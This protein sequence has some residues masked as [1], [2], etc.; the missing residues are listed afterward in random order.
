MLA[1]R[2]EERFQSASELISALGGQGTST[3]LVSGVV[4]SLDSLVAPTQIMPTGPVARF[5][6]FL[7]RRRLVTAV[8]GGVVALGLIAYFARPGAPPAADSALA[9]PPA[10]VTGSPTGTKAVP[11]G[12]TSAA[13]NPGAVTD[14][15]PGAKTVAGTGST[16]VTPRPA[17]VRRPQPFSNCPA[18]PKTFSVLVDAVKAQQE[19]KSLV[20][21]YDVCGLE[22]STAFSTDITVRRTR[23]PRFSG[24]R[25][26]IDPVT[27]RVLDVAASPRFRRSR[28]IDISKLPAGPYA[29][30]VLITDAK[31]RQQQKSREFDIQEK[32]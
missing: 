14:T 17:A 20:F 30:D 2:Q 21:K 11:P 25:G 18:Q 22:P 27:L 3:T 29:L 10:P 26:K 7:K 8:A 23:Q 4:T 32:K 19:G 15:T 9:R 31:N 13:A 16:A 5:K 24:I 1:K 28:Q 12:G 6:Y